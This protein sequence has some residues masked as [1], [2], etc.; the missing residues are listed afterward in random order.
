METI[1]ESNLEDY[2]IV[3]LCYL[4]T[5]NHA[6]MTNKKYFRWIFYHIIDLNLSNI[7]Y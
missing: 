2:Y 3:N 5:I 1:L 7:N 4:L 6:R